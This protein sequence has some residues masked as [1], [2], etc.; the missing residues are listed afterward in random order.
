MH[1]YFKK[2][3]FFS[4]PFGFRLRLCVC[5]LFI[6]LVSAVSITIHTE[7]LAQSL[8][9]RTIND[10]PPSNIGE[11]K[12]APPLLPRSTDE[13][14]LSEFTTPGLITAVSAAIVFAFLGG[15]YP[16][17]RGSFLGMLFGALG[18]TAIIRVWSIDYA[19]NDTFV[20]DGAKL[21]SMAMIVLGSAIFATERYLIIK[22]TREA[23]QDLKIPVSGVP[24]YM[25]TLGV[26]LLYGLL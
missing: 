14:S 3:E 13:L 22:R 10:S 8:E 6:A 18:A 7:G 25:L 16:Q 24:T 2:P 23:K 26:L 20:I 17:W 9:Q 5:A 11:Q 21:W 12:T 19:F 1:A 4:A 15:R